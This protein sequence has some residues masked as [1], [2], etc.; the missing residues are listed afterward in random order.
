MAPRIYPMRVQCQR[1]GCT[2]SCPLAVVQSGGRG[3]VP[4]ECKECGRVYK[5]PAQLPGGGAGSAAPW[6]GTEARA[7]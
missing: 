1:H 5:V 3:G 4:A 2:G 7:N 6:K